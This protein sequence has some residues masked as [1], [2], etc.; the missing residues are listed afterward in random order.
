[1]YTNNSLLMSCHE[2]NHA[3]IISPAANP[4]SCELFKGNAAASPSIPTTVQIPIVNA[5]SANTQI[6]FNILNILNPSVPNYPIGITVKLMGICDNT[7]Q[8]NLCTFY[9]STK[10]ITFNT[11]STAIPGLNTPYGSLTF[12]PNR[13]SATNTQHIFTGSY[14]VNSGDYL[15]IVYYPQI[16]IPKVCS[17]TSANGVCYSYPAENTIVIVASTTQSGSYTF[18]MSGM[19]NLYQSRVSELPSI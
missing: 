14:T 3:G 2:T 16:P 13:V 19:T 4:I 5:I 7:D 12:N 6:K 9:R 18:T 15:R 8:N 10:Y 1:M 11:L 17:I